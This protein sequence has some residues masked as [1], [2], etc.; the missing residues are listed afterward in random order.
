[1]KECVKCGCGD[2]KMG[3]DKET[4]MLRYTCEDCSYT[5]YEVTLEKKREADRFNLLNG[6]DVKP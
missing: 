6:S 4:D 1:M 3:Y 5:W 2:Y